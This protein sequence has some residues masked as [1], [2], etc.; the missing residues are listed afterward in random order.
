MI[1]TFETISCF[2]VNRVQ[3]PDP[4]AS[5]GPNHSLCD[6]AFQISLA[7]CSLTSVSTPTLCFLSILLLSI[8]QLTWLRER[9]N[10]V[11]ELFRWQIS[12]KMPQLIKWKRCLDSWV[13]LKKCTSF[14][15]KIKLAEHN[16][17]YYTIIIYNKVK[18]MFSDS[19]LFWLFQGS[20]DSPWYSY[21]SLLC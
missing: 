18:R 2:P 4:Q 12:P 17:Y 1:V 11:Q 13:K 15:S 7:R 3:S 8:D 9:R 6:R 21:A 20:N 16:L 19:T 10:P 5:L 14:L